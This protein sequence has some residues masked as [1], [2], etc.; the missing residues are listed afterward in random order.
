MG[1]I[2][3]RDVVPADSA[4]PQA[5]F[6]VQNL[7]SQR[8]E[9]FP[10]RNQNSSKELDWD[11][12]IAVKRSLLLRIVLQFAGLGLEKPT[13][14]FCR[15]DS[16]LNSSMEALLELSNNRYPAVVAWVY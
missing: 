10:Y 16:S 4:N 8:L 6:A 2:A 3:V 15:G 1:S 12:A 11:L 9:T 5:P 7:E 14:G 13:T